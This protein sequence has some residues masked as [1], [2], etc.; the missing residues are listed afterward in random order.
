MLFFPGLYVHL[1]VCRWQQNSP[2][3][4][5]F[6]RWS[7]P[8]RPLPSVGFLCGAHQGRR[9]AHPLLDG[10]QLRGRG[11]N[12]A[13]QPS[14]SAPCRLPGRLAAPAPRRASF[15]Q[16]SPSARCGE[17]GAHALVKAASNTRKFQ[18]TCCASETKDD[19]SVRV[20]GRLFPEH[21]ICATAQKSLRSA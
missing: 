6:Y 3:S 1:K 17:N 8:G 2:C 4:T 5:A 20:T 11:E 18:N 7:Q 12:A 21:L 15:T 19:T 10:A 14:R 9:S 16:H 13:D